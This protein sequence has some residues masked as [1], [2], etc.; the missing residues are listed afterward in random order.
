MQSVAVRKIKNDDNKASLT[1][2]KEV[3]NDNSGELV[4]TD[5]TLTATGPTTIENNDYSG[6]IHQL[7]MSIMYMCRKVRY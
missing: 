1:L 5:W 3:K 6:S 2:I 7:C 4:A